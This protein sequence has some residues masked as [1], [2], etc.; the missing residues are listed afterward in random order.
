MRPRSRHHRPLAPAEPTP[1]RR[2]RP[3][4]WCSRRRE[5]LMLTSIATLALMILLARLPLKSPLFGSDVLNR[6]MATVDA[7]SEPLPLITSQEIRRAAPKRLIDRFILDTDLP[8]SD[9]D[10][11]AL[12]EIEIER[13]GVDAAVAARAPSAVASL[14]LPDL[15]STSRYMQTAITPPLV[16]DPPR[17]HFGSMLIDYPLS[18][19]KKAVEGLVIVRFTVETDGRAYD[20]DIVSSLEPECDEAVVRALRD[21][22]FVPGKS[23][24]RHVPALSQIAVR[25]KIEE[26]AGPY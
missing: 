3:G 10:S 4:A 25:F 26:R 23:K 18:A 21:A 22:R 7:W 1:A 12:E 13:P 14:T 17:L 9:L 24:G 15:T 8:E 6:Y 16:D 5:L 20:I 19:L 11:R 2:H